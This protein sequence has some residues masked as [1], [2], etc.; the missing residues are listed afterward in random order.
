MHSPTY[1][2]SAQALVRN[3]DIAEPLRSLWAPRLDDLVV[4]VDQSYSPEPMTVDA[5]KH[6]VL[7][8]DKGW[9]NGW[10]W[11]PR[12]DDLISP[13]GLLNRTLGSFSLQELPLSEP[14]LCWHASIASP[15]SHLEA[16]GDHPI[17]ACLHLWVMV[18]NEYS[19]MLEATRR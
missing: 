16:F 17:T 19:L 5:I 1:P 7:Q 15:G 11:C 9:S 10:R 6:A 13:G 18:W 8:P 12:L 14:N 4:N 2:L 3:P